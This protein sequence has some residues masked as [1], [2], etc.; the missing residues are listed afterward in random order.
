[1]RVHSRIKLRGTRSRASH[2]L[3]NVYVIS[4]Y[5]Q[6]GSPFFQIVG[7]RSDASYCSS[8]MRIE[9]FPGNFRDLELD[10]IGYHQLGLG[11]SGQ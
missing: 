5:M 6:L 1:M 11:I 8:L 4:P 2:E 10:I 7:L 3:Q 9:R